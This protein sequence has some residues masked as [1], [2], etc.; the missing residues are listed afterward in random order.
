MTVG[1]RA[2]IVSRL[3]QA[4][5]PRV[6]WPGLFFFFLTLS[7]AAWMLRSVPTRTAVL[8]FPRSV[9]FRLEGERRA[10]LSGG[11]GLEENARNIVEELLLGPWDMQRV[12]ALPRGTRVEEIL[13]RR[14]R[15]FVDISEDAVFAREPSLIVGIEAV[16]R[17]LSFN[18]PTLG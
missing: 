1:L 16:R 17:T 3:E 14:G 6:L 8:F 11:Y 12:A 13:F 10:V 9:D 7:T 4:L 5:S 2:H 15:L 18:F